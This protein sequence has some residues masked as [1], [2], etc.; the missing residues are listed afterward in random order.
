M[1]RVFFTRTVLTYH[2]SLGGTNFSND[3]ITH[4]K[5]HDE[6]FE[7]VAVLQA[8]LMISHFAY[9]RRLPTAELSNTLLGFSPE[10]EV[11]SRQHNDQL[12]SMLPHIRRLQYK[13]GYN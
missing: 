11:F 12:V 7:V 10:D 6:D 9:T 3:P 4:G 5:D 8:L 2:R 1:S 13:I